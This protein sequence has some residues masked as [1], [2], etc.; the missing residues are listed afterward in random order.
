M[1]K[2]VTCASDAAAQIYKN[3]KMGESAILDLMPKVENEKLRSEMVTHLEQYQQF[4][5]EAKQFLDAEHREAKEAGIV[6]RLSSKMGS[7]MNTLL[8]AT[9]SHLAEMMIEGS[10]M[11]ITEH[12]RISHELERSDDPNREAV[13]RLAK[14]VVSFEQKQIER[15]KQ[16]L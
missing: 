14:D 8:D 15:L 11:G 16:Y 3:V 4:A 13:D 9:T 5:D 10:T 1:Q 2:T 6:A 7:A 12:T